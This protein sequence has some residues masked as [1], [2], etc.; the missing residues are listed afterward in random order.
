ML[1]TNLFVFALPREK[2]EL[3]AIIYTSYNVKSILYLWPSKKK[4]ALK[5]FQDKKKHCEHKNQPIS[6]FSIGK[7][8]LVS[9]VNTR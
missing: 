6:Q 1:I 8:L 9:L 3:H 5:I 7:T 2:D 4:S